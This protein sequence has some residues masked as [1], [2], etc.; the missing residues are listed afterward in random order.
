MLL[1]S[2]LS[3]CYSCNWK[4]AWLIQANE[5]EFVQQAIV[6]LRCFVDETRDFEFDMGFNR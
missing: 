6:N 2:L 3:T 1:F 4:L 5:N